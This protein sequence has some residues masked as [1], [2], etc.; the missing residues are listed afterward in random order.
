ME[1]GRLT[2]L[3]PKEVGLLLSHTQDYSLLASR[4]E[5]LAERGLFDPSE[6]FGGGSFTTLR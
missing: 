5:L 3:N 6:Y 2:P 4:Q 1:I